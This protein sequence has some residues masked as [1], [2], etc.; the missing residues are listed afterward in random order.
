MNYL[1]SASSEIVAESATVLDAVMAIE[2]SES[3][4]VFVLDAQRR[5]I[6]SVTDGDVRRGI[7][8]GIALAD[9]VALVMNKSPIS[10][11][12]GK[13]S[14]GERDLEDARFVAVTDG[15]GLFLG[16]LKR[17]G[18]PSVAQRDFCL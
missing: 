8:R 12:D 1:D 5:L 10:I 11:C 16:V 7:L 4:T 15:S 3:K 9:S 13:L 18:H 17:G 6:G 2:S 14:V